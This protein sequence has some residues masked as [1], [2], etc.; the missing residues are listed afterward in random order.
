M[1]KQAPLP[2]ADDRP[3]IATSPA[4]AVNRLSA[5]WMGWRRALA[6]IDPA[7]GSGVWA[8][9]AFWLARVFG[10]PRRRENEASIA[11]AA[12][13]QLEREAAALTAAGRRRGVT[14][15]ARHAGNRG[16]A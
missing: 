15:K 13:V 5:A 10:P 3:Q 11:A 8:T 9:P 12:A 7:A 16:D 4:S 14:L 6:I 1:T 2:R